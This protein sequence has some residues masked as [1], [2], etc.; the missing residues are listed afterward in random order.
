MTNIKNISCTDDHTLIGFISSADDAQYAALSKTINKLKAEILLEKCTLALNDERSKITSEKLAY[1][2]FKIIQLENILSAGKIRNQNAAYYENTF[3]GKITLFFLRL[4]GRCPDQVYQKTIKEFKKPLSSF[5][6]KSKSRLKRNDA[7]EIRKQGRA[8]IARDMIEGL[9]SIPMG[10][11]IKKASTAQTIIPEEFVLSTGEKK[12]ILMIHAPHDENVGKGGS[13]WVNCAHDLK[14]FEAHAFIASNLFRSINQF[15][16]ETLISGF[17]KEISHEKENTQE[18]GEGFAKIQ[19]LI[20][21]NGLIFGI[22]NFYHERDLHVLINK[23]DLTLEEKDKIATQ[24]IN[25]LAE[26][27]AQGKLHNDLK[28]NNIFMQKDLTAH[29]GDSGSLCE[30]DPTAPR[31]DTIVPTI[32]YAAPEVTVRDLST[33]SERSD[34]WSLGVLLYFLYHT[35]SNEE[36]IAVDDAVRR[37]MKP[38]GEGMTQ[39]DSE[40]IFKLD[41]NNPRD[42]LI[43]KMLTVDKE[44][45]PDMKAV[46]AEWKA[47]SAQ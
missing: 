16:C 17:N 22:T 38:K 1:K 20:N 11:T 25:S 4:F 33:F 19:T 14:T 18:L 28:L 31:A 34:V 29:I 39:M 47:I 6:F 12:Q 3:F 2:E 42:Q 40:D 23:R 5:K 8:E 46:L 43:R 7:L 15:G 41:T 24:I 37:T 10:I 26:L 13:K 30:I 27:H 21:I 45:R 44:Q 36:R 32:P 35:A 9:G